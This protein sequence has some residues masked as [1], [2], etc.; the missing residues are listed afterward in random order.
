MLHVH[1]SL[2]CFVDESRVMHRLRVRVAQDFHAT[3]RDSRSGEHR[4]AKLAAR[5]YDTRYAPDHFRGFILIHQFKERRRIRQPW[6]S[7]WPALENMP[8]KALLV[9]A[10]ERF[11]AEMGRDIHAPANDF[12]AFDGYIDVA[13]TLISR[14]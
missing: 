5:Q 2:F 8:V 14:H 9:P 10:I 13:A 7:L 1:L 6:V 11:A 4:P 3:G 12:A